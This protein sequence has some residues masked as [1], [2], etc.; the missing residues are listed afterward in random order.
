MLHILLLHYCFG[1]YFG[2]VKL[3]AFN[4]LQNMSQSNNAEA[5][6]AALKQ[7]L[8][9]KGKR[10]SK[11]ADAKRKADD[12]PT[13]HAKKK[14]RRNNVQK[15]QAP[16]KKDKIVEKK[17]EKK[18]KGTLKE[19]KEKPASSKQKPKVTESKQKPPVPEKKH[20]PSADDD[21]QSNSKGE[22]KSGKSKRE[23]LTKTPERKNKNKNAVSSGIKTPEQSGGILKSDAI[24]ISPQ[25]PAI[26]IL[27]DSALGLIDEL[28]KRLIDAKTEQKSSD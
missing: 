5:K 22:G 15:E 28:K 12:A 25:P 1:S 20:I 2:R 14:A 26:E 13:P 21:N 24:K 3:G 10:I 19:R 6:Y 9:E 8:T 17:T 27:Q 4:H 7:S 23:S 18:E 16:L 11:K